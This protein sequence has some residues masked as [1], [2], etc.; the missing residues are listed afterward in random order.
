MVCLKRSEGLKA[1]IGQE[2]RLQSGGPLYDTALLERLNFAG[3]LIVYT[4]A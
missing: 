1:A 4:V 3:E 2:E